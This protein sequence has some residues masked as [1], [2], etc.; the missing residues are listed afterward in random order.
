MF[1]CDWLKFWAFLYF[2]ESTTKMGPNWPRRTGDS[3]R[4]SVCW[5][6]SEPVSQDWDLDWNNICII[7]WHV[8]PIR[9]KLSQGPALIGWDLMSSSRQTPTHALHLFIVSD[10]TKMPAQCWPIEI[11]FLIYINN[12]IKLLFNFASHW[13]EGFKQL[14]AAINASKCWLHAWRS[15]YMLRRSAF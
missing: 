14:L 15:Y 5:W 13:W 2:S 1:S 12:E 7:V 4:L 10:N 3:W 6:T 9:V 8:Q 11:K